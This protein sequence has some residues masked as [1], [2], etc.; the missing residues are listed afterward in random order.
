MTF[1]NFFKGF[2]SF[3][4]NNF[5]IFFFLKSEN[6]EEIRVSDPIDLSPEC[7]AEVKVGPVLVQAY[8]P[9]INIFSLS[10]KIYKKLF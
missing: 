4:K 10:K 5:P 7:P 6:S 2:S 3:S 8:W 1:K 9:C